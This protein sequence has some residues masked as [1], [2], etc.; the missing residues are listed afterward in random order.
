M[1]TQQELKK[2]LHYSPIVGTFEWIRKGRRIQLY[3]LAGAVDHKSG[4]VTIGF[5]GKIYRAHTL[6]WLYMTGEWPSMDI[7]HRDG[8]KTNNAFANLRLATKSQNS[9]NARTV[10]TSSTGIKGVL[11]DK[12][13]KKWR[14]VLSAYGKKVHVGL[15]KTAEEAAEA[16]RVRREELHGEFAN[17]GVHKYVLEDMDG[18]V[19]T[20]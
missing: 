5:K 12:K 3:S 1:V 13:I 8:D 16:V 2:W 11:Y 4:Y 15:F 18:D 10:C 17:H 14:A 19:I 20:S 6:A 9:W 7:D